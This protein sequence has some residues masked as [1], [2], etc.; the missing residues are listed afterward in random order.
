MIAPPNI[1]FGSR[2][3]LTPLSSVPDFEIAGLYDVRQYFALCVRDEESV[4]HAIEFAFQ[5]L[6]PLGFIK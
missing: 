1:V 4:H 5:I 2:N 3:V 6:S